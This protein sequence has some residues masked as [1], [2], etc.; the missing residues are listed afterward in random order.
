VLIGVVAKTG[1]AADG[2]FLDA[3]AQGGIY[4]D[5]VVAIH[6]LASA[7]IASILADSG[8]IFTTK[9]FADE[10]MGALRPN[11]LQFQLYNSGA[12]VQLKTTLYHIFYPELVSTP[13][14]VYDPKTESSFTLFF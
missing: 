14:P 2:Y 6:R 4:G 10:T 7:Q 5:K 1:S 11:T 13:L 3:P 8:A 12:L 9:I